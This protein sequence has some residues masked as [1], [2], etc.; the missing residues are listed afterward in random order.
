[1]KPFKW[2]HLMHL[3][4]YPSVYDAVYCVLKKHGLL[5]IILIYPKQ[6]YTDNKSNISTLGYKCE[7]KITFHLVS[8]LLLGYVAPR[9]LPSTGFFP[10]LQTLMCNTDSSCTNKSYLTEGQSKTVWY[11]GHRRR[12]D[13]QSHR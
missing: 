6:Y 3:D 11:M 13:V 2:S 12:R 8:M 9:N 1:M 10:F 7:D 4:V 5:L